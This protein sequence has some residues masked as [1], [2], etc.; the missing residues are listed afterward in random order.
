VIVSSSQASLAQTSQNS[1]RVYLPPGRH[2]RASSAHCVRVLDG[3][4]VECALAY[5]IYGRAHPST[6]DNIEYVPGKTVFPA[7][8][9]SCS[10]TIFSRGIHFVSTPDDAWNF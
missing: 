9:F 2:Y 1:T 10:Q 4:D 3:N 6:L 7:G 8:G 5:S